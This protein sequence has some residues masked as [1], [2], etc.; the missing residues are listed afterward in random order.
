[1]TKRMNLNLGPAPDVTF[2][3]VGGDV[4][5]RG[6]EY[7]ETMID[8][9]GPDHKVLQVENSLNVGTSGGDCV[10]RAPH[11][12]RITFENVG[13]DMH[14]KDILGSFHMAR[15]GGDFASRRTCGLTI[16]SIGGDADMREVNG[17]L[18]LGAASGDAVVQDCTG[19]VSIGSIG[20]DCVVRDVPTGFEIGKVGGDLEIRTAIRPGAHMTAYA[21]GD[22]GLE[23]PADSSVRIILPDDTDLKLNDGL[24]AFTEGDKLIVTLGN[25]EATIELAADD[26]VSVGLDGGRGPRRFDDYMMNVSTQIENH[27]RG[28]E[29]LDKMDDLPEKI[30]SGVERRI[31]AAMRH[32]QSAEREAQRAAAWGKKDSWNLNQWQSNEPVSETE[33]MAILKML[34]EG[35]ITVQDAQKLLAALEGEG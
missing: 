35:K 32:V 7:A 20:G 16:G 33:R 2:G 29:D 22:L 24:T 13:G 21:Q 6:G 5:V 10:C 30:R 25:G 28:L 8:T 17:D 34:E 19:I 12:V 26:T 14:I 9:D 11:D 27:L 4:D 1:M 15:L 23:V 18:S 31:N 3:S